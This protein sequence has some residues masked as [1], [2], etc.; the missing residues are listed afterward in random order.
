MLARDGAQTSAAGARRA[1]D[2]PAGQLHSAATR[3][4]DA[5]R[6]AADHRLGAATAE[7]LENAAERL[8]GG[9]TSAP[10]WPTLRGHLALLALTGANPLA[11]LR[12][13]IEAREL[14]TATDPA[15]VLDHRLPVSGPAGPLPWLP[16]IPAAL[17]DDPQWGPYLTARADHLTARAARVADTTAG[18]AAATAPARAQRLLGL[19][20]EAL[21]ADLAVWR[22]ALAVPDS[23]RR[24][25][26]PPRRPAPERQY[27]ALLDEA[28]TAAG[29]ARDSSVWAA[30]ADGI[31]PR[32]RR[33]AHWPALADRLAAADRAGLDAAG[34]LAAVADQRPLPDDLPA[35]ALWWRLTRHLAPATIPAAPDAAGPRPDWCATL[36]DLLPDEHAQRVLADPAWPAL[37]AAITTGTRTGWRPADLLTE[38]PRD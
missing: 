24:P 32:I 27:Q 8:H 13:A 29:P 17:V 5:L 22:A 28:V 31:D 26:G 6:F 15:A 1:L 9:L 33:D 23:D 25:T 12:T 36:P 7:E 11:L 35:A 10:A 21:R 2:D 37:V 14:D 30:L 34:M 16:G 4:A 3:Y 18:T 19:D 38:P 20:Q